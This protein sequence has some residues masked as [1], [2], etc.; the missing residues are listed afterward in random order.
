[1]NDKLSN[2]FAK[3]LRGL[4]AL[5]HDEGRGEESK[6]TANVMLVVQRHKT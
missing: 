5:E 2:G 4:V 3:T 6:L 1:M